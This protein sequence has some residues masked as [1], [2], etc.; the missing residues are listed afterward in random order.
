VVNVLIS[1]TRALQTGLTIAIF[2]YQRT[3]NQAVLADM[4][5]TLRFTAGMTKGGTGEVRMCQAAP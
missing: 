2:Q 4:L 1:R 3:G 5:S